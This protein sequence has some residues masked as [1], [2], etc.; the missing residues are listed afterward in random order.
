MARDPLDVVVEFFSTFGPTVDDMQATAL[1]LCHEELW[2]A[3]GGFDPPRVGSRQA[4]VDDLEMARRSH[5]ISEFRFEMVH[6]AADGDYVLTERLD[7]AYDADGS[8]VH[9]FKVMGT[10]KVE[11]GLV[12]W[13]R[14]YFYDTREFAANYLP[15]AFSSD[16]PPILEQHL[17]AGD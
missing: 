8:L 4:L 3:S 10:V 6:I 1:R 14:D 17:R 2:W 15:E 5:G 11:D 13:V 9:S 12:R 16:D 7:D